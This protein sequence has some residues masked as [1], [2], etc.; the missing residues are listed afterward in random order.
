[1]KKARIATYLANIV[2]HF[3]SSLYGFLVPIL[4]PIFFRSDDSVIAL[5]EAYGIMM[6]GFLTRPLGAWYFSKQAD[7]KGPY[8]VLVT[9]IMGMTIATFCFTLLQ[10]YEHWGIFGA[11]SLCILRGVQNFF[12][13]GETSIA[14]LYVLEYTETTEQYSVTATYLSSQMLGILLACAISSVI[15]CCDK[16]YL[17]WK[18]PFYGSLLAGILSW[19][20]RRTSGKHTFIKKNIS[21]TKMDWRRI[22]RLIPIAGFSYIL[23]SAPF[24][25][26]N[27]FAGIVTTIEMKNLMTSNTALMVFDLGLLMVL[28][29]LMKQTDSKKIL[30]GTSALAVLAIPFLFW[31][32]PFAG[33]LSSIAIRLVIIILGVIFCIPLH[34]WYIGEFQKNNRYTTIAIGTAIGS[35]IL[36]RSFPAVGLGLWHLTHSAVVPGIYISIIGLLA[37]FCVGLSGQQ[38][39]KHR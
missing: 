29:P 16:P 11:L 14:G 31:C 39:K 12:G 24:V 38:V 20:L 18:W 25:F 32:I 3:D 28:G 37:F 17:Y 26:F 10:P 22:L 33:F 8:R 9:T 2:E 13:A 6:V 19:W 35:E 5:V 30:L 4:A 15:F 21:K 1:M 36:G 7:K 23:Y 27:S 34:R